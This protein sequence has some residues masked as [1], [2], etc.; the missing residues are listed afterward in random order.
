MNILATEFSLK[1]KAVEIYVAGCRPPHCPGCHNEGGWDFE[2]GSPY[3]EA[4]TDILEKIHRNRKMI[5]QVWLLGG[6][7]LDQDHANLVTLMQIVKSHFPSIEVGVFTRYEIE[8]VPDYIKWFCDFV[9]TGPYISSMFEP[10]Y[11]SHGIQLGSTNQKVHV[12]TGH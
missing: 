1:H 7:P 3:L 8:D 12:I 10:G 6:E 11:A 5:E 2:A 9:K 4:I